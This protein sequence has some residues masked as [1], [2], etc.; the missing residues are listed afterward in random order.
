VGQEL[1]RDWSNQDRHLDFSAEHGRT[2]GHLR[3]VDE[4]ARTQLPALIR[5]GVSPQGPL[6]PGATGEVAVS[7]RIELLER[8]VLEIRDVDRL[9]D[10]RRLF[11]DR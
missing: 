11:G 6:V 2:S 7:P 5:L 9:G 10:A 8:Q 4:D 1:K 3:D